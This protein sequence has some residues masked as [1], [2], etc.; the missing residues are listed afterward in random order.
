MK[1]GLPLFDERLTILWSQHYPS[2]LAIKQRQMS[3]HFD[4]L[5][6]AVSHCLMANSTLIGD[7]ILQMCHQ[8]QD[9]QNSLQSFANGCLQHKHQKLN[10]C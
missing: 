1:T 7:R 3:V 8:Q 6:A 5:M 2:Y 9:I 4:H 10:V